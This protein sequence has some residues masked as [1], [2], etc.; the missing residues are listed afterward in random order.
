MGQKGKKEAA[1]QKDRDKKQIYR[2]K[3]G[4]GTR[5]V[6]KMKKGWERK[7]RTKRRK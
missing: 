7:K 4:A 5:T 1:K 6:M 2:S 3:I